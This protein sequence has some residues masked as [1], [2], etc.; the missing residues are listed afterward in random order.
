MEPLALIL[1]TL[2]E[3]AAIRIADRAVDNIADRAVGYVY[4]EL[5]KLIKSRL[6]G[7]AEAQ[8]VDYYEEKNRIKTRGT[9]EKQLES[10]LAEA[11]V[12]RDM[13]VIRKAHW[14]MTRLFPE[15][16][17]DGEFNVKI[18][19]DVQG[20]IMFI[21]QDGK[22]YK[23]PFLIPPPPQEFVGR[24]DLLH[25]V[26]QKLFTGSNLA[27]CGLPGVGKTTLALEL[28]NDPEVQEYF[29]D[30]ILWAGLGQ[31]T[32]ISTH[33]GKWAVAV[34][35]LPDEVANPASIEDMQMALCREIRNRQML[36]VVDD[37]WESEAAIA[38]KL[39]GKKCAHL[40]TTRLRE[41]ALD[42][43]KNPITSVCELSEIDG[44]KLLEIFVP[45]MVENKP[46]NAKELIQAVGALP[47][48]LAVIGRYLRKHAD[49]QA[50]LEIAL[51]QLHKSE[52]WLS[53]KQVVG[54]LTYTPRSAPRSLKTAIEISDG[55]LDEASRHTLRALSV[56]PPKPN[57][58]S[59]EA[60]LTVSCKSE[61]I[62][63][64]DLKKK[65]FKLTD[66]KLLEIDGESCYTLQRVLKGE[67]QTRY[68][69][70]Q[71]IAEYAKA[72]RTDKT[73][74]EQMIKFYMSYLKNYSRNY[75][76]LDIESE[77]II[78]ALQI[79]DEQGMKEELVWGANAIFYYLKSK[80]LYEKARKCLERAQEAAR[81]L[82][83][84]NG[85]M[86][87]LFNLGQIADIT[88]NFE[89][90]ER[91]FREGLELAQIA[92]NDEKTIDFFRNL[93][94]VVSKRGNYVK[95]EEYYRKGYELT[96][97]IKDSRRACGLLQSLGILESQRGDYKQAHEY[98]QKSLNY[99][100]KTGDTGRISSIYVSLGILESQRGDYKQ[101][102][103]Y[104]D[105]GLKLAQETR[106][107]LRISGVD[108]SL[109]ILANQCGNFKQAEKYLQE[110]LE[111]ARGIGNRNRISG[112]LVA[113]GFLEI[114]CGNYTEAEKFLLEGLDLAK[115]MGYKDRTSVLLAY[116]GALE[117]K[118]G[119]FK[120]AEKYL[121]EGLKLAETVDN[122]EK[123]CILRE[124]LGILA[125]E[126]REFGHAQKHLQ[127]GL[128]LA[129]KIKNPERISSLY[130]SLGALETKQGNFK[131]A[132][133][134][135]QKGLTLARKIQHQW[136]IC[137]IY[138]EWGKYYL[139]RQEFDSA[140]E[141]FSK[142]LK[143]AHKM[144]FQEFAAT[145]LY[146]LAQV[147]A[148]QKEID[149]ARCKSQ[150]SLRIFESIGH[151]KADDVDQ[152]LT[153]LS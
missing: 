93:G 14:I 83:D 127:K 86:T 63:T 73:P 143:K 137:E 57:N 85:L 25:S 140:S 105:K 23:V 153:E 144:N 119:D 53:L 59:E 45:E 41:V 17:E 47:L 130:K 61:Q 103:E 48:A 33:L 66:H 13:E 7:G 69:L 150:E 80:R 4:E 58:F 81:S 126:R 75:E 60:A 42:F 36:L 26:K 134:H 74:L 122:P 43:T 35:I 29:R 77:N 71:T 38:F 136:R 24:D 20:S 46:E 82:G 115:G 40:V 131:Q 84:N 31:K 16:A 132:E 141:N 8:M 98:L 152:L 108:V 109:G 112:L 2:A 104:L 11:F 100:R 18:S 92:N 125:C 15:Q 133:E 149:E 9:W 68:M 50:R 56:F 39:G 54:P 128:K 49:Q 91:Y 34:G 79:A 30:G 135:L 70:H 148:A 88:E 65:L 55:A 62:V 111:L 117:T 6:R 118:R 1:L 44:L 28:V 37:A 10:A 120:Q 113:Y 67:K 147:A 51:K 129:L 138:N 3:A 142:S 78:A 97:K 96:L 95:A 146:G 145:A 121:Q 5:K 106:D 87:I 22:Q 110:G 102:H 124:N 107:S 72:D 32:D 116:L 114:I 94:I 76:A 12:D 101:A 52:K 123:T 21:F 89:N 90:A 151:K 139:K 19:G 99:G 27:L 64:D